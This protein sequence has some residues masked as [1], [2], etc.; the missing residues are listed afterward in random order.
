MADADYA[1]KDASSIALP[2]LGRAL[3]SAGQLSQKVAED[4]YRKSQVNRSSFIAELTGSGSV[5]P[6]NLAH[7]V[8]SVF[9]APLLD[10]EAIDP[11][12]LPRDVLDPKICQAYRVIVLSKRNNRLIVATADPTDQEAAEKIKFTTQMGVDW[13]IAEY[14]KLVRLVDATTKSTTETMESMVSGGDFE[15][16]DLPSQE[17]TEAQDTAATEVEDAPIVKFL[18]KMLLDAFNMRASDLHFEPYEHQY[19]VRF[20]IDGELREIASPPIAIKEKLASR[21]KVISR[22]DISEKR[23]PQDGRM[24]LKVGPD[25]V[26]D[27]RVSTLPTL[28]GEKIVIRILDP[29]SAKLGI[30]AL[31]YEPEEK[32]RLL[33]AIGRPYGMILVTGPTGSGK[34]VSLYTCLNLLN[35][36]GV[37]IATAEDPS[38]INLP[39][40][41]QVNVN[42]KAGLT[43]ATALKSFL[44]QDPDI[45]MV[46]EIR[47]LETADISIK[48]AQTG[49]LVLST[50]HTNDAPTTL[51]RMRNM[52]I[53]PF[54]IASSVILITAQRLARRLCPACKAPAD[55]PHETLLEAGYKEEDIDGSWVTYRPVG[56]SACNNGYKGRVGIYQVMPISEEIQRIIL[57][58]GSAL[59]IAEQAKAEGVRSLRESGLHKARLGLTSLE[60]VLA[61]TNE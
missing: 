60:E 6:I 45:I 27:F 32:E 13:I 1:L 23:V 40:V 47:D 55:I 48:A 58:D 24:K 17:S 7:T 43:F 56:C 12:R 19:R 20:R 11:L 26:I 39:G 28:F 44:R 52:G 2:G 9:G 18:H 57:R 30:D 3:I 36:P 16:D 61:V 25:R 51:T 31:G 53:A 21:I 54:N 41:N 49:H 29:S 22:L 5:S 8:S 33:H 38:E 37:N 42:E 59:E 14:D 15:F 10:I 35:K 50:L 4:I 34:T 46:G